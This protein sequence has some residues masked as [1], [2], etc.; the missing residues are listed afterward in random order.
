MNSVDDQTSRY[1]GKRAAAMAAKNK[2]KKDCAILVS[3]FEAEFNK[4]TRSK[5]NVCAMKDFGD[6]SAQATLCTIEK[7]TGTGVKAPWKDSISSEQESVS[8]LDEERKLRLAPSSVSSDQSQGSV[9]G[10]NSECEPETCFVPSRIGSPRS[11]RC[12]DR[13]KDSDNAP[14]EDENDRKSQIELVVNDFGSHAWAFFNL[15][16]LS[17]PITALK[18]EF[19]PEAGNRRKKYTGNNKVAVLKNGSNMDGN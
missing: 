12:S 4:R 14:S 15:S 3:D 8:S 7:Q 13:S 16:P 17:S 5:M 9:D 2:I 10:R 18:L 6:L 1:R 19:S 11:K